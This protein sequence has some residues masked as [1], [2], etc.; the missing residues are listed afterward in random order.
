MGEISGDLGKMCQLDGQVL[1]AND[2]LR[3]LLGPLEFSH[4]NNW[5][6]LQL[7]CFQKRRT[8]FRWTTKCPLWRK[9]EEMMIQKEKEWEGSIILNKW[10][11]SRN[12]ING[13]FS[14]GQLE[15]KSCFSGDVRLIIFMNFSGID[16]SICKKEILIHIFF[17]IIWYNHE[18]QQLLSAYYEPFPKHIT[19]II[20]FNFYK[21][22]CGR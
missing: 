4:Q 7:L 16:F 11:C 18:S 19:W 13:L 14:L 12:I 5:N 2:A 15:E 10:L 20:S 1:S 9:I 21:T 17:K 22:V 3:D 6:S 8:N